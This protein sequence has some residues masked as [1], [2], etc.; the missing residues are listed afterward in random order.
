VLLNTDA[1]VLGSVKGCDTCI[2]LTTMLY[3]TNMPHRISRTIQMY[4]M[5][6]RE[7]FLYVFNG[8][9]DCELSST[10][11]RLFILPVLVLVLLSPPS[12]LASGILC[13]GGEMVQ[14]E[15]SLSFFMEN[16]QC[17]MNQCLLNRLGESPMTARALQS[18]DDTRRKQVHS[19]T[20]N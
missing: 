1:L 18:S 11:R 10:M 6:D 3:P 4:S 9:D 15:V 2:I 20:P 13:M 8:T 17:K 16:I 5:V 12:L 7:L 14:D 19:T